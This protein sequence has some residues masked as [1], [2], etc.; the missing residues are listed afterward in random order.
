[1]RRSAGILVYRRTNGSP[2][3]LLVHPGGPFWA[4]K[5]AGAWTIPKGELQPGEAALDCARREFAEETGH[6]IDGTFIAL[7]AVRQAGGKEVHAFAVES[8]FDPDALASNTFAL[9]WP[10]RSG[11]IAQFPE[12]DR[13]RW[14]TL[15]EAADK[16]NAA[17]RAW[18]AHIAQ[19]VA[20]TEPM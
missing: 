9:E 19:L 20:R 10:P 16:I 3:V 18:L 4:R 11:R 12:V 5:D 6:A 13:A 2:E 15:D 1:M 14:F 7:P 8:E 17:Q